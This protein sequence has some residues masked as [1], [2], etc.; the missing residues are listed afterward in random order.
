MCEKIGV[1]KKIDELGRIV[2]PKEFRDRLGFAEFVEVV[3]TKKGVLICNSEYEL[4]K[5]IDKSI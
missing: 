4:V 1:I 3:I 2:I 5:K